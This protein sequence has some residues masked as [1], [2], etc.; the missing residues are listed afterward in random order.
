MSVTFKRLL[1]G[2]KDPVQTEGQPRPRGQ[3]NLYPRSA[4]IGR[5]QSFSERFHTFT[6]QFQ[7]VVAGEQLYTRT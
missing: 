2:N 7:V 3:I 4:Q 6:G 1:N 5:K